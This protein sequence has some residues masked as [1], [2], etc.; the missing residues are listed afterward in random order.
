VGGAVL[1]GVSITPNTGTGVT[2]TFSAVFTDSLG[3]TTDLLRA[4]V[5]VGP[6]G[7]NSCVIEY[8]AMAGLIRLQDDTG[9]P[10]P[11][12]P[13]GN[14]TLQNSQCTLD[15]AQTTAVPSGTTLTLNLKLTFKAPFLGP[16]PIFLRA[17]S[18]FGNTTGGVERGTWTVGA[19]VQALTIT[20]VNGSSAAG[21]AQTFVLTFSDSAGVAADLTAARVRFRVLSTG[22]Q[23][24]I[25][26]NAV[27]DQVRIVDDAGVAG[28]FTSFGA[29]TLSNS[30]CTLDLASSSAVRSGNDLTLTLRFTFKAAFANSLVGP[31][32]V[33]MLATSSVGWTTNWVSKGS[34][35]VT[36]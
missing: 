35:T 28:T 31:K 1:D 32:D 24:N 26:Y 30:Q 29:G 7:A 9:V 23:C 17:T 21:A 5:R 22:L 19:T 8:D 27:L 3:V 4:R 15:L 18:N 25:A 33:A 13:L 2:Q 14:G 12:T 20:P 6:T 36:P 16:Q 11:F 34:W 10:G